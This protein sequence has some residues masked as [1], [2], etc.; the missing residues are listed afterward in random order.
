MTALFFVDLDHFKAINDTYG[1]QIG[2]ELLVAVGK[3]LTEVLRPGDTLARLSG[4]EFVV[5]CEDLEDPSQADAIA[6]RF[7]EALT[8][9][10]DLTGLGLTMKASIGIAYAGRDSE[11]PAELIH[12]ADLAMYRRKRRKSG[13]HDVL[14]LRSLHLAQH[15]VGLADSVSGAWGRG[16]MHVAYQPI[17]DTVN[18]HVFAAEALLRWSHPS[19]GA[20][21]PTIFIP[22]AEQSGAILELGQ[23]VLEQAWRDRA[24]WQQHRAERRR[25]VG[26]RL[27]A[28]IHVRGLCRHR[29]LGA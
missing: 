6:A 27:R 23:R 2:D 21:A 4:D 8:R 17:V 15:Q 7:N 25:S 9:P 5:V 18:G 1:H 3:R 13:A 14:D 20:I 19:R 10:F 11:A 26:E 29:G 16:E 24:R 12:D 22:F 28:S